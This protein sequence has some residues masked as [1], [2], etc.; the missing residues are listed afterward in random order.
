M[1][2]RFSTPIQLAL[3]AAMA[4]ASTCSFVQLPDGAAVAVHFNT[5]GQ[6][7]GWA[8]AGLGLCLLP[9]LAAGL[10]AL[11]WLLPRVDPRGENLRRS[12]KGV[13]TIWVAVTALLAVVHAQIVMTALGW[14]EVSPK[15]PLL[16]IGGLFVIVGN[17]LGKLRS[18]FTVG[19]RTP[20][21]LANERV[22]DQTHR[23]AGKV[24][25]ATGA[26]LVA[27]SMSSMPLPWQAPVVVCAAL[28]AAGAAVLKSYALWR[29]Q[30]PGI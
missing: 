16:L 14:T 17:M 10:V 13:S 1:L 8:S 28:G 27:L 5:A 30:Q 12:A 29:R 11:Q 26:V 18:N 25:V 19:I 20:W 6:V 21:T 15:L 22:W 4:L 3:I 23:F 24:F 9:V 2:E 7:D